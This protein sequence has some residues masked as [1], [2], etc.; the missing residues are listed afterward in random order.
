M[1]RVDAP[2]HINNEFFD[3]NPATGQEATALTADWHNEIQESLALVCEGAGLVLEK[4]EYAQLYDAIVLIAAGAAGA[5]GGSVPTTR[6]VNTSGLATGG[7]N[8]VADRTIH[9][10]KAT[11]GDVATGTDDT[12]AVTPLALQGGSGARLL[13][14]TGYVTI[15]GII[16]QWGTAS[17]SAN[18]S[19]NITLPIAFPVQCVFADFAG[20]RQ[21]T[22]AQDNDPVVVGWGAT[23]LTVFSASDTGVTGRYFAIGF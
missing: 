2:G 19:G 15:F 9:V 14:G 4:G 11:A 6:L 10:P 18:G 21:D 3:G 13:A 7:G 1:H 23:A 16:L 8:L 5:G 20:G 22:G 17:I 12:K